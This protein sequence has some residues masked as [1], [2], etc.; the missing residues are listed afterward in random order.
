MKVILAFVTSADGRSTYGNGMN[1]AKLASPED[2]A[3][4]HDLRLNCDVIIMG[5][6]T[7]EGVKSFMNLNEPALRLI[8]THRPQEFTA[9]AI[10]GKL[11]F[12]DKSPQELI[13][14][15]SSKGIKSVLLAAGARLGGQFLSEGLVD[16][17]YQTIEPRYVGPGQG[18]TEATCNIALELKKVTQLN[19]Q[20]TLL[21]RYKVLA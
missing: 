15:L 16:E 5:G 9:H 8:M 10:P 21:L 11:E 14:W 20:G 1:F 6:A 18:I 19:K 12:T 7:Y 13:T 17:V 3:V 4:F 2:Q